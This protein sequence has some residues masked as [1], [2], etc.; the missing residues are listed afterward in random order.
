MVLTKCSILSQNKGSIASSLISKVEHYS[1]KGKEK[2]EVAHASE[3]KIS[4][5]FWNETHKT[6]FTSGGY[7]Y[8]YD[9]SLS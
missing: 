1:V 3:V 7:Q 5:L 6:M 2:M 4:K 8:R 9:Q